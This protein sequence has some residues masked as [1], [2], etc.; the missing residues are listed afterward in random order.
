MPECAF[1]NPNRKEKKAGFSNLLNLV[2]YVQY[3]AKSS[4]SLKI[5]TL[6]QECLSKINLPISI[7]ECGSL[8][9]GIS[10]F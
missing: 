8:H 10:G 2:I 1:A 6:P 9:C 5:Y 7:F 4:F 3:E